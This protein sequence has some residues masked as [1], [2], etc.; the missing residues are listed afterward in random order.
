MTSRRT[1]GSA[2]VLLACCLATMASTASATIPSP[3]GGPILVVTPGSSDEFRNYVPEIMRGEG[4]NDFAAASVNSLSPALLSS[5]DV[6]VLSRTPLSDA[7]A[8]MLSNWVNAGGNLIALRP[9]TRLAGLLGISPV[10]GATSD[11]ANLTV[12]TSRA[13]GA[14]ITSTSLQYHGPADRYVL[15]GATSVANLSSGGPAVTLRSVG[16]GHAAAFTYDLSR[17]V[18]ETRQGNP[19]W[20]TQERDHDSPT[21]PV[22]RADDMFFGNADSGLPWLDLSRATVP[23]ADEQQRLLA[24]LIT[25]TA[26][27]PIPRFWYLPS[28]YKAAVVLTG[29]DHGRPTAGGTPQR[30]Q[31]NLT[32]SA[33]G[34]SLIDWQCVRSTS[35]IYPSVAAAS[36]TPQTAQSYI[37]QGFEIALHLR[38]SGPDDCTP[39]ASESDLN[40]NYVDQLKALRDALGAGLPADTTRTHCIVW[41]DFD[42]QPIVEEANGIRLDTNYYYWPGSWVGE[43]PGLLTGSALPMRFMTK[44]GS[45]LDVYQATTELND[46]LTDTSTDIPTETA[47]ANALLDNAVGPNG[48]YG[49]FTA[50]NHDDPEKGANHAANI[51]D[52]AQAHGVPVITAKQLLT[53]LDGRNGSAFQGVAF[54]GGQLTFNIAQASGA[55]G[56]QAMLPI[57]GSTGALQGL[58]RNGAP[59]ATSTRTVKGID[60]AVFDAQSGSYVAAYPVPGAGV[61]GG[62]SGAGSTPGKGGSGS[63]ANNSSDPKKAAPTFPKV[64]VNVKT[65]RLGG[66]RVFTVRFKAKK[67]AK[68]TLVMTNAK[69]KVVRTLTAGRKKKGSTVTFTWNGRDKRGKFVSAGTYRFKVTAV[70]GKAKQTV[71]GSVKVI[72]P[73]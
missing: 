65:F 50:N 29:D 48:Y 32:A 46:E 49:V 54:N 3:P 52:A 2:L 57:N 36:L 37:N 19:A 73:K 58:S 20:A 51:V 25:E 43:K 30:F 31:E 17:S 13:P 66:G 1:I 53:W 24:N 47:F 56:L 26:R 38:V 8:A 40:T 4:L 72:R 28:G 71:K 21:H 67:T 63:T 60:Y 22:V 6:V 11:D 10:G 42:S 62:G 45:L 39:F 64:L 55:H 7:Q 16:A 70:A 59:V 61:G 69:G 15:A 33:P 41:S 5:Y 14:G 18:V 68:F 35:Y 23:S 9:D 34:C 44:T 12:D 27:T